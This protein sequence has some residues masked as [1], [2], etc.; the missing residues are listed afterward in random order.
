MR[1][2]AREGHR[3][4][5]LVSDYQRGAAAEADH[6]DVHRTL[7]AYWDWTAGAAR[8]LSLRQRWLLE[9]HNGTELD[10]QLRDYVPD[11]VSWW[12][13]GG[14][15]LSLIERVRRRQIPSVLAVLDDWLVYGPE[16]DAWA[17]LARRLGRLAP[18]VDRALGAP[19]A[20][21]LAGA[22]RYL[23]ISPYVRGAA[24]EIE[25]PDAA[26][27]PAGI[28]ERFLTPTPQPDWR[29]K[30]LYV[31]RV[32]PR[33]G[34]DLAVAALALLPA[35]ATLTVVGDGEP[36]YIEVLREQA[37]AARTLD[38]V[39]FAGGAR[40]DELPGFY[41]GCDA[42]VFPPRW[43]EPWGLVPLEAMGVGRPLVA[44]ATGG[45]T[46]FLRHG[47]NSL[48][49]ER[50]SLRGLVDSL[51]V[52]AADP[53][54]RARIRQGGLQTAAAHTAARYERAVL[55]ELVR[56]VAGRA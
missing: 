1:L 15:S 42:V 28:H 40:P 55:D 25:P 49:F 41:A 51:L 12:Q 14:M 43:E 16:I 50:G 10:R 54:L 23:F 6:A 19:T 24:A 31:G 11:V 37:R 9:R 33:K 44:A 17:R 47:V 8:S 48:L 26:V 45:A 3:V 4:R 32:D 7:R 38:R 18:I 52:L 53:G 35:Q 56:A 13:M 22:G 29:W 39:T 20:I 46:E 34:V 30:L 2:A 36:G 5:V 27:V 21:D